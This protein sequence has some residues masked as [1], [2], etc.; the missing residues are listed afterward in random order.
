[1]SGQEIGTVVGGIV[2]AYFGYPQLGMAIGGLIGGAVDPQK[3]NGPHIGQGQTQTSTTGVPIAWVLGTGKVA[4]TL[5]AVG[6]RR[7]VKI[8]DSGK[9]GPIVSHYE[10]RQSFAI[11][12]AESSELRDSTLKK[13]IM[14]EQD[15]KLVYDARPGSKIQAASLKWKSGVDF[16]YGAED[17]LPHPTLEAIYGVGSTPAYRGRC[18]AVFTDFNVTAAGDRIPT[19]LF[20][21]ASETTDTQV[22][23][24]LDDFEM[25]LSIPNTENVH[26]QNNLW[27]D[28]QSFSAKAAVG[29]G[30]VV[31]DFLF[32]SGAGQPFWAWGQLAFK[33]LPYCKADS[34]VQFLNGFDSAG[35]VESALIT[36]GQIDYATGWQY[37]YGPP[38]P[39][40]INTWF[41]DHG[42]NQPI[43]LGNGLPDFPYVIQTDEGVIEGIRLY[44]FQYPGA[45]DGDGYNPV[46]KFA[47]TG[48]R[49]LARFATSYWMDVSDGSLWRPSWVPAYD[50]ALSDPQALMLAD[51]VSRICKRGGLAAGDIDVSGLGE[52]QVLGYTIATQC[53]GDQALL[54]LLQAYFAFGTECDA[55]AV[56]KYY[57]EDAAITVAR[58]D[59]VLNDAT[60][61][62]ISLNRRNQATEFPQKVTVSYV[63]PDQNY[64]TNTQTAERLAST[65]VA[66]GE[67]SVQMPVVM[68]AA[69][70][71][72]AA[73]K[74]LKVAYATLE[75]T[76]DYSVPYV[77]ENAAYL[78]LCAGEP[79]S[80]DGKRWIADDVTISN[81]SIK[82]ST[83]YDR[84][85]AYTSNVQ[86]IIAPPPPP[87]ISP[88]SG[89][90]NLLPMNL[91]SLRPQDTY[92]VYLAAQGTQSSWRGCVVQVSYDGKATWQNAVTILSSST[93][94]VL[95]Q[96]ETDT[97]SFAGETVV[98]IGEDDALSSATDAQLDSQAN[99]FALVDQDG[100]AEIRQFGTA[101]REAGS[102]SIPTT[103]VLAG[104]RTALLG[105]GHKDYLQDDRFTMLDAVYFLPIDVTFAGKTLYF[106]GVGFG[107][108]AENQAAV[109]L[110]YQP[111]TTVI[112]DGGLVTGP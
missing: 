61:G 39:G 36:E 109:P 40:D 85:S 10:A 111:D 5:I 51:V 19:F 102:G 33:L 35:I 4:G 54:P 110:V 31:G 7:E 28:I 32:E 84:Q 69:D 25:T 63:D 24:V 55:K 21:V 83:R 91:P 79:V 99:A 27:C 8:H 44:Q 43:T 97:G 3:I 77:T 26:D 74:A 52:T 29:G 108:V 92:G 64:N 89:P 101:T 82:L 65:V 47:L 80:M 11:L 75:G 103:W 50:W 81:M 53:T 68:S 76:Q 49:P 13:V 73:D 94:G 78:T 104:E 18:V 42:L 20:T 86:P 16:M 71:I 1:M 45:F 96:D 2:G 93:M 72:K 67:T 88:Y 22:D 66:I 30:T 106:R 107:E 15:G 41:T 6:P 57:G 58:D 38:T 37:Y 87:P 112:H 59:L 62:A 9:G 48:G 12:I 60:E 14:V 105:T 46:V 100:V 17:Q 23:N 34:T 95:A 70:A 90:T 98:N 56:F